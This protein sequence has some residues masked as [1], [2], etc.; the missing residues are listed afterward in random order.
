MN[1][2]DQSK[3]LKNS[4]FPE[5]KYLSVFDIEGYHAMVRPMIE[6]GG[7]GSGRHKTG[8]KQK[9]KGRQA[10]ALSSYIPATKEKLAQATKNEKDLAKLIPGAQHIG[11]HQPF[12]ILIAK[13]RIGL[14]VKTIID[15]KKDAITMHK[16]SR[17]RKEK[18]AKQMKLSRIAT[19]I[20]DDRN[21]KIYL[22]EGVKS[23]RITLRSGGQNPSLKMFSN[24]KDL[25]KNL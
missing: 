23:F 18:A 19:V 3:L 22:G 2:T 17:E 15:G 6:A 24:L 12:D 5:P 4:I 13:A 25:V 10:R 7:P 14:E 21:K 11:D 8:R 20:F 16:A 1:L 9:D